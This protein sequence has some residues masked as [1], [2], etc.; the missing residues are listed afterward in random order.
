MGVRLEPR[1]HEQMI[2]DVRWDIQV[3]KPSEKMNE[4]YLKSLLILD[5]CMYVFA[6]VY[7]HSNLCFRVS[8]HCN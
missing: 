8:M 4:Y 7:C 3:W 6:M 2:G 1:R 5:V